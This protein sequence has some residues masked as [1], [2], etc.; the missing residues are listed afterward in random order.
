MA[1]KSGCSSPTRAFPRKRGNGEQS[2]CIKSIRAKAVANLARSGFNPNICLVPVWAGRECGSSVN[3]VFL[4][5]DVVAAGGSGGSGA[6]LSAFCGEPP[7]SGR[8]AGLAAPAS[9]PFPFLAGAA[10]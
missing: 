10:L 9:A 1:R 5:C 7:C 6:G 2:Y 3:F 8:V 4:Q